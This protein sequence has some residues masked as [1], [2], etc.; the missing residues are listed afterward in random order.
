[1]DVSD[2]VLSSC[3]PGPAWRSYYW[4]VVHIEDNRNVVSAARQGQV[5]G[6]SG[7]FSITSQI[8]ISVRNLFPLATLR[9]K[10]NAIISLKS[11]RLETKCREGRVEREQSCCETELSISALFPRDRHN[12]FTPYSHTLQQPAQPHF[13]FYNK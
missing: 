7:I 5:P 12:Y 2:L 11:R 10:K 6:Q 8:F 1:M 3:L 4:F 13:T 9:I